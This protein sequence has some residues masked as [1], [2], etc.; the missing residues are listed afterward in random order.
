MSFQM[1]I[2]AKGEQEKAVT[3]NSVLLTLPTRVQICRQSSHSERLWRFL[4]LLCAPSPTS[5]LLSVILST[6]R[7]M[8]LDHG[9]ARLPTPLH[10]LLWNTR[11]IRM[12]EDTS[13]FPK[14][15]GES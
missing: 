14:G 15:E 8:E 4:A 7:T 3:L 1:A 13:S 9:P 5:P 2:P 10:H 11:Q 6:Y 12:P